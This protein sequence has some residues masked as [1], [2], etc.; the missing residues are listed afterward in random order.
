MLKKACVDYL[1]GSFS[2]HNLG[3]WEACELL[4]QLHDDTFITT[5]EL[6]NYLMR[7]GQLD[8]DLGNTFRYQRIAKQISRVLA[9]PEERM[10][11]HVKNIIATFKDASISGQSL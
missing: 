8:F 1:Y 4:Q 2:K 6:V 9:K 5:Q 7:F 11:A 10:Y 3:S